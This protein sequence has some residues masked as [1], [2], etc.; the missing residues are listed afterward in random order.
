MS[1]GVPAIAAN[2]APCQQLQ[3]TLQNC[4]ACGQNCGTCG[5]ACP[6][7]EHPQPCLPTEAIDLQSGCCGPGQNPH[8]CPCG[9][10]PTQQPGYVQN[11]CGCWVPPIVGQCQ[12]P[13]T[14]YNLAPGTPC[15]PGSVA[16]LA[17]NST[18]PG[19][20]CC[21]PAIPHQCACP[22]GDYD[23]PLGTPCPIGTA[24]D[25][26][27]VDPNC[28][29]CKPLAKT[30]PAGETA[31]PCTTGFTLDPQTGCC[32][33]E[34]VEACFVCPGGLPDL[35]AA[36]QGLPNTCYLAS[37]MFLPAGMLPPPGG[38]SIVATM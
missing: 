23:I 18:H 20:D 1:A 4:Q 19:C 25:P 29:C 33:P 6:L 32:A 5:P 24:R 31:P 9:G 7:N 26:S 27:V 16:D 35:A 10:Q 22:I 13:S 12:C 37:Q 34:A 21:T 30:C 3:A 14:D 2:C 36:L 17:F 8:L 38:G 15:P 11:T 28:N